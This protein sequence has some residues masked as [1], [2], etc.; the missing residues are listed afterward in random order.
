MV[1]GDFWQKPIKIPR[2]KQY[3]FFMLH[4]VLSSGVDV[5]AV[6][7]SYYGLSTLTVEGARI[8]AEESSFR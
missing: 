4:A 2:M 8:N 7:Q 3:T 6:K 5:A 1:L